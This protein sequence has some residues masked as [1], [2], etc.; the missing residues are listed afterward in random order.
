MGTESKPATCPADRPVFAV[1]RDQGAVR[2][3]RQDPNSAELSD[4]VTSLDMP[5]QSL[6]LRRPA[7]MGI[8]NAEWPD[9]LVAVVQP[10][11]FPSVALIQWCRVGPAHFNAPWHMDLVDERHE[12]QP[13]DAPEGH[14]PG[15]LGNWRPRKRSPCV[16]RSTPHASDRGWP[17]ATDVMCS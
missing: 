3:G 8:P 6:A 12:T 16:P 14:G 1:R 5:V 4:V 2:S 11:G 17:I 13:R 7:V 15:V 9:N 10:R